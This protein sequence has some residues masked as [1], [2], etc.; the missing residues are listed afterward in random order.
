MNIHVVLKISYFKAS[1]IAHYFYQ[2]RELW[3]EMG[4]YF[5]Q[6]IR[7]AI[8]P[9]RDKE[10]VSYLKAIFLRIREILRPSKFPNTPVIARL[11][12]IPTNISKELIV[13]VFSKM[14][15]KFLG[16]IWIIRLGAVHL[17]QNE[18]FTYD[19]LVRWVSFY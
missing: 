15:S 12:L 19:L 16:I 10:G 18:S 17:P 9:W 8:L 13:K 4:D 11:Y 7:C 1:T 5:Y 3:R 6:I 14:Y 2:I